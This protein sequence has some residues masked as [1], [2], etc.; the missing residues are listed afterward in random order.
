LALFQPDA[1]SLLRRT[2]SLLGRAFGD[3]GEQRG[4]DGL[5]VLSGGL[6]GELARPNLARASC[7]WASA[8]DP[9]LG[10]ELERALAAIGGIA[11]GGRLVRHPWSVPKPLTICNSR[12]AVAICS[13]ASGIAPMVG[14]MS[15]AETT[16]F[17]VNGATINVLAPPEVVARALWSDGH[18]AHDLGYAPL[19]VPSG[20]PGEV[21]TIY[22]NPAAVAQLGHKQISGTWPATPAVRVA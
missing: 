13:A 9:S 5:P 6:G 15:E 21:A 20:K 14:R 18:D 16:L 11:I 17:Y 3:A 10:H 12:V 19:Q 7:S 8:A 22:V 4:F 1:E 2:R